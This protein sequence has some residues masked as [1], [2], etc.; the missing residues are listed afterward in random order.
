MKTQVYS[1]VT[2]IQTSCVPET[3]GIFRAAPRSPTLVNALSSQLIT[4]QYQM[5]GS[6]L[7]AH[8]QF[9]HLSSPAP[10]V[11]TRGLWQSESDG[12]QE[13]KYALDKILPKCNHLLEHAGPM[14]FQGLPPLPSSPPIR[15]FHD[16]GLVTHL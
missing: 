1:P 3:D 7:Q 9:G 5:S 11:N 14:K 8:S 13:G 10:P 12:F 15:V 6:W 2:Q 4:V 16:P